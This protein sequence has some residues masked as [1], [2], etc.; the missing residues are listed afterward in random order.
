MATLAPFAVLLAYLL[1]VLT[2][3]KRTLAIGPFI[4]RGTEQLEAVRQ[5]ESTEIQSNR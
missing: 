3:M 2:V 4:L 1:R 5:E